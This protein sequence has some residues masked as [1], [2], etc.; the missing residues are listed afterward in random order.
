MSA[1]ERAA[2]LADELPARVS[3]GEDV[4]QT[5]DIELLEPAYGIA[6]GQAAVLYD[7]DIVLGSATIGSTDRAVAARA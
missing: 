6:P 4:D 2:A 1:A 3:V 7:G 5:V